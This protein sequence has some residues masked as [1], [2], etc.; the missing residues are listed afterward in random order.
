MLLTSFAMGAHPSGCA[1][2]GV[3]VDLVVARSAVQT[4]RTSALVDICDQKALCERCGA[5]TLLHLQ[6]LT[7]LLLRL[8]L[9]VSRFPRYKSHSLLQ[10]MYSACLNRCPVPCRGGSSDKE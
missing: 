9:Y 4:G 6:L 5:R 3:P 10:L 7:S 8:S 2:A 1:A